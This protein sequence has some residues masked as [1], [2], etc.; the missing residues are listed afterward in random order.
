MCTKR[1]AIVVSTANEWEQEA[2][3]TRP[4]PQSVRACLRTCCW[5]LCGVNAPLRI[6]ICRSAY[7][8]QLR[9]KFEL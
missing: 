4:R 9:D 7:D 8:C 2:P 3:L 5:P 1:G 6:S